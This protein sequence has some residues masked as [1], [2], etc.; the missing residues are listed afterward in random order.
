M[1]S[2][3]NVD[4]KIMSVTKSFIIKKLFFSFSPFQSDIQA[5]YSI[6]LTC[7]ISAG[8]KIFASIMTVC[9]AKACSRQFSSNRF[10]PSAVSKAAVTVF[11]AL[12][13]STEALAFS[14]FGLGLFSFC[15]QE[16]FSFQ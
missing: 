12:S 5:Y 16:T 9:L 1:F 11:L 3:M 6:Q 4:H 10:G 7:V 14:I 13:T 8:R 2:L 15:F